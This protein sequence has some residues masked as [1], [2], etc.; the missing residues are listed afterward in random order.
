MEG[1]PEWTLRRVSGNSLT[2]RAIP[3]ETVNAAGD[4]VY[5]CG[6]LLYSVSK[7]GDTVYELVCTEGSESATTTITVHSVYRERLL[8][9]SIQLD[10]TEFTV[11]IGELL[12]LKPT[13]TTYPSD[14]RLPAGMIVSCEGGKQYQEALNAQDTYISQSISTF[15]F[16][17][18][19]T[20]EANLI[21]AYS[22][23]KYVIPVVF[24]VRD[25]NGF[26]PVQGTKVMLNHPSLYMVQGETAQMEAV[27]TPA[28]ATNQ[29]VT[30]TSSDPSVATVDA[31]G[32]VTAV[33]NG[34][35]TIYC[36]P[37]DT[38]CTTV[39]CGVTV[40]DYLTVDAGLTSQTLYV[41]GTQTFVVA[42]PM[43]SVGTMMRLEEAGLEPV[44]TVTKTN[45]VHADLAEAIDDKDAGV[46][47]S[48]DRL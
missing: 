4:T 44:W 3:C 6:I 41:Q 18:A 5:G 9:A 24:R 7:E 16:S 32:K 26:V 23:M 17:K 12:V 43:L 22:N 38:E 10:Q 1:E 34:T 33:A 39:S 31:T 35:A 28:N 37:A 25:A 2:L 42:H 40:E 14:S 8:P 29:A 13:I 19:G 21:Y 11:D 30:W 47:V 27:F 45:V 15:S 20:Y 48:T 46:M 36:E